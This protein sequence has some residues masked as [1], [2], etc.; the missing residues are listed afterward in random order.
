MSGAGG[1]RGVKPLDPP[2]LEIGASF[3]MPAEAGIQSIVDI[4]NFKDLDS[5]LSRE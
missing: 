2:A 1:Q 5:L 4:H 3:V